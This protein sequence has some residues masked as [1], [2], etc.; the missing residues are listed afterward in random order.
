[1]TYA[2]GPN[3]GRNDRIDLREGAR[4]GA[5]RRAAC[6]RATGDVTRAAQPATVVT[7]MYETPY[8]AHAPMEPMNTTADVRADGVTIWTPTQAQ[9][10]SQ[11]IARE[12][13]RRAARQR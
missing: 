5:K 13:R 10:E 11:A 2:P 8:L 9:T 4:A 1:M 7:A 12:N 3:A 6:S